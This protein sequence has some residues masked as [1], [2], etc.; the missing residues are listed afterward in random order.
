MTRSRLVRHGI[1]LWLCAPALL[2]LSTHRPF[3][4]SHGRA[5]RIPVRIGAFEQVH[6][7][8][9]DAEALRMLDA[10]DAVQRGYASDRGTVFLVAVFHGPDWKSVHPPDTCLEGSNM[11]PIEESS[12]TVTVGGE[13][14]AVG[15]L[16]MHSRDENRDYLSLYAYVAEDLVT[17]SYLSFFLHHAPRALVRV[18][19][20]GCLVRVE[21][22]VEDRAAAEARCK[23]FLADLLP[24]IRADLR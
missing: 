8:P 16:L 13:P 11:T 4:A 6:D 19:G 7:Y 10:D 3:G 9:L 17:G 24:I 18:N 21:T 22:W 14:V 20:P 2:W 12:D 23:S 15:R 5:Q 1:A